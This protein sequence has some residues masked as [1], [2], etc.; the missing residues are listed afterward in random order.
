[1]GQSPDGSTYSNTPSKYILVQ[2]NADL[3]D[4]WVFPPSLDHAKNKIS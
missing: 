4:G 3:K 2:G 1:M